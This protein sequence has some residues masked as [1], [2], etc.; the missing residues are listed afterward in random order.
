MAATS[1]L[2]KVKEAMIITLADTSAFRT[3]TGTGNRTS[4]KLFI[5]GRVIDDAEFVGADFLGLPEVLVTREEW[6]YPRAG[7]GVGTHVASGTFRL[8]F[9]IAHDTDETTT[10]LEVQEETFENNVG[11]VVDGMMSLSASPQSDYLYLR[12]PRISGQSTFS[13]RVEKT[14]YLHQIIDVSIDFGL[15]AVGA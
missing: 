15:E 13:D 2:S 7:A 11:N 12:D 3:W 6:N 1:N 5:H 9:H 8:R 4:A 14:T 10:T